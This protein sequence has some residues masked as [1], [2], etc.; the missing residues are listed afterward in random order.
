MSKLFLPTPK[1]KRRP[2]NQD[3]YNAAIELG[4]TELQA[5]IIASRDISHDRVKGV[6]FPSISNLPNP[7]TLKDIDKAS[8]R[9]ADAIENNEVIGLVCDF[10]V[11]GISSA[12]VLSS[13]LVD[14]FGVSA[15][16]VKYFI[17]NRMRDGYGFSGGVI[18]KIFDNRPSD[19][20]TLLITA[21]QGSSDNDRIITYNEK[22]A[23]LGLEGDV[24]VTD[25]HEISKD[26]PP[27]KAHSFVNPQRTDCEFP[28]KTI[29]GCTV[30][31]F[32]MTEV[33]RKLIDRNLLPYDAP[34]LGNLLS[35][36]TAATI[37]DCVSMS[38]ETNRAIVNF[39][40]NIINNSD[41]ATWKVMREA[42]L[43]EKG[44][45]VR[46]ETIGFGIGPRINACSRTGGDGLNALRFYLS[47]TEMSAYRYL[48]MLDHN[49]DERK[50]IERR[51]LV[52]ATEQAL[53]Q[54]DQ[55]KLGV[56][57]FLPNGHH[58]IHGIVA[59]RIVEK[60]GRPVVCF[61]PKE[62]KES[63]YTI[64]QEI[65]TDDFKSMMGENVFDKSVRTKYKHP[66]DKNSIITIEKYPDKKLKGEDQIKSITIQKNVFSR[67]EVEGVLNGFGVKY[68][69][70]L[71]GFYTINDSTYVK[72]DEF[73]R[74]S[75]SV[76]IGKILVVSGSARS[77]DGIETK[78]GD[79]FFNLHGCLTNMSKEDGDLFLGFGGHDMAAG[80]SIK[81]DKLQKF[82]E[83]F[84]KHISLKLDNSDVGPKIFIDGEIDSRNLNVEFLDEII[85]LEPFGRKFEYPEFAL[86]ATI[87]EM[88]IVGKNK[89]TG[90][91]ALDIDGVTYKGIWFKFQDNSSYGKIK[92]GDRCRM[93][94]TL[95]ENI[96]K[97]QRNVS[98]QIKH[99]LSF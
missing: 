23:E 44:E 98:L 28:D 93:V 70:R 31:L 74:G 92:V 55:G 41:D 30:A 51:L 67:A 21:D 57:V 6:L 81:I 38:S 62:T 68:K 40:L 26:N 16:N 39:G 5:N 65:S 15:M 3:S 34:R 61:S 96:F 35:Y 10:D 42:L 24:I 17:S 9:V 80:M 99:A 73:E 82:R 91:F 83:L 77:I 37:A 87:K 64:N 94:V 32:L 88:S 78:L 58:G 69:R 63:V 53:I 90:M 27:T 89:D 18:E 45:Q 50:E 8:E 59:S 86:T 49:N 20:P 19:V 54:S 79:T 85:A 75:W 43:Q 52:E 56:V 1:V 36:S 33:R 97:G 4:A 14:Y 22:M 48:S 11:D 72:L 29:C 84:E 46:A 71:E 66:K 60:F 2:I 7:S 13:A 76:I 12:A 47:N 95:K 25:H